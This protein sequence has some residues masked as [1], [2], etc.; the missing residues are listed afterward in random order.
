MTTEKS[1]IEFIYQTPKTQ[2]Q[3]DYYY[4]ILDYVM[5][6]EM[7]WQDGEVAY[8]E[9]RDVFNSHLQLAKRIVKESGFLPTIDSDVFFEGIPE[10]MPNRR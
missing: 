9:A 7:I 1:Y 10:P 6:D 5:S 4:Q 3:A 2:Q 8:N